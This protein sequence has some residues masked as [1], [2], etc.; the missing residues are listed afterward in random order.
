MVY[1]LWTIIVTM[2]NMLHNIHHKL[3][4]ISYSDYNLKSL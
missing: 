4:S 2:W 3:L 1:N